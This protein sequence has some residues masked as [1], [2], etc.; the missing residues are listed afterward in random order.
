MSVTYRDLPKDIDPI[1]FLFGDDKLTVPES[2][3]TPEMIVRFYE[4]ALQMVDMQALHN[5]SVENPQGL[6][7]LPSLLRYEPGHY[8]TKWLKLEASK[9]TIE[10]AL[11]SKTPYQLQYLT[12]FSGRLPK[13][14]ELELIE[15]EAAWGGKMKVIGDIGTIMLLFGKNRQLYIVTAR[16]KPAEEYFGGGEEPRFLEEGPY[17]FNL[18]HLLVEPV[19]WSDSRV[20]EKI[21]DGQWSDT[22]AFRAGL[23]L[24][25]SGTAYILEARVNHMRRVADRLE[26]MSIYYGR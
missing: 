9:E 5:K 7:S 22:H 26:R 3:F 21:A 17:I 24:A 15:K 2:Y 12:L 18:D 13:W 8:G 20:V 16:W 19:E 6:E 14:K 4:R 11:P 1:A 10:P 23:Q 25:L